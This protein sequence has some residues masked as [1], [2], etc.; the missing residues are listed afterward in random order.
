MDYIAA[1]ARAV[2]DRTLGCWQKDPPALVASQDML[3]RQTMEL[4]IATLPLKLRDLVGKVWASLNS[5]PEGSGEQSKFVDLAPTDK[6]DETGIY[7]EALLF[8][9]NNPRVSNIALTGPYGSGKSSIIQSFLKRYPRP[10]LQ[11]SLAAF[12]PEAAS[13]G[14]EVSK[15]E[16]ERSILQQMLYGADANHLPLSRFKRI[17][18]PGKLAIAKSLYVLVGLV[19]VW[20]LV[21]RRDAIFDGVFFVPF[22][23]SNWLNLAA[24]VIGGSFLWRAIHHLYVASFG[25]SLKSISLKDIEIVPESP[26]QDSILNRH[27]DEII[28]FFQSTRYD[29]VVI[30][31]LDRF[32]N[33]EI[34]VTLREINSLVNENSG[35][36][37]TIR[38]LYAL[39][40]D[41][42]VNTDRTKFFE[43]LIPVIPIIHSSNSIDKVLEQGKRLS[44]DEELDRQF[45]REVSRYLNDL[46]LIQNIFNEYAIYV[47]NLETD[48]ENVLDRNK[49]LAILI[50]KN[51]FPRDFENLHHGKGHLAGI[52]GR[53]AEFVAKGEAQLKCEIAR[54]EELTE[55]AEQQIPTDLIELRRIYAMALIAKLPQGATAV[56]ASQQ[57]LIDVRV[58]AASE[59]IESVITTRQLWCQTYQ[60]GLQRIDLLDFQS[61]VNPRRTYD[62][63]KTEIERRSTVA[64]SAAAKEIRELRARL[65]GFR[66]S[67]FNEI[68][69]VNA[70]GLEDLFAAFGDKG[71]LARYLVFEGYLDDTYYQFT[72][73]FHSGRLSPSDNKFLIQIR[74]FTNPESMYQIDNP[75]EVIAAM[76]DDDFRQPYVLNVKIADCLLGDLA[77]YRLQA[78][79]MFEFIAGDFAGCEDFLASYYEAGREVP[80]LLAGLLHAWTGFVSAAVASVRNLSHIAQIVAHLPLASLETLPG[81]HPAFADFVSAN[82]PR[83]LE[84][85]IILGPERLRS[86]K[87]EIADLS[88]TGDYPAIARML[89]D[90]GQ[91]RLSVANLEFAFATLLGY[92]ELHGLRTHNYTTVLGAQQD[93]LT[94]RIERDFDLYLKN[95]LLNLEGNTKESVSAILAVIGREELDLEDIETFLSK[96]EALLPSLDEVPARLHVPIYRLGQIEPSWDNCLS[97]MASE[98]FE[99]D[100]LIAYL[101]RDDTVQRLTQEAIPN[102]DDGAALRKFLIEADALRDD[103]Y[104]KYAR[105]LPRHFREF[106][107][108]LAAAKRKIVIEESKVTFSEANLAALGDERDLRVL[109]VARNIDEYLARASE[110]SFGD[111]FR[112]LLLGTELLEESKLAIVRLMDPAAIGADPSRAARVGSILER[113]G[114]EMSAFDPATA[115]SIIVHSTPIKT[116]IA[117]L[118]RSR[119]ILGDQE[120]RDI[121]AS[122]PKPF[123]EIRTGH[124]IPMIADTPENRELLTWLDSRKIISSWREAYFT[125]ELRINLR[126]R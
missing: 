87:I 40:D 53:Q 115:R 73:L 80:E 57:G 84:Q 23:T 63:R 52:L 70:D 85:G 2:F 99:S 18:S 59:A 90:D 124:H 7:S 77:A 31:D 120:V 101:D 100:S 16:I 19:A 49:L 47:A 48:G 118:N 119:T 14:G 60:S 95:V 9:T 125:N 36:R 54:L 45:L 121:L 44:L 83:I 56:G 123:S 66:T 75:K 74:G 38:F 69:R 34:F 122:L 104:R 105:A 22:A 30:E 117:L 102:G 110:F 27:L 126:R 55:S 26:T 33:S 4:K 25:V 42:F 28:Y 96:Q 114:A 5:S 112:D 13:A 37:R 94:A 89:V 10:S 76:R 97:F 64:K 82:L 35:V 17:Q 58:L 50:Y 116:Q 24:F 111:D 67:K 3:G 65:A 98:A 20:R 41:M 106:P 79:G 62:E 81:R 32:N 108:N 46:R 78:G 109:F 86:L 68:I 21:E 15:Q 71:E 93:A 88:A 29:L 92:G 1:V 113:T 11:I 8:A 12:L 39:R 107:E 72:S 43:F 91:F 103:P 61:E 6:A 51:V